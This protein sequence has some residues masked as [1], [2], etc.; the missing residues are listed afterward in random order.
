MSTFV[1]NTSTCLSG[2]FRSFKKHHI[3][4]Y[5]LIWL[6]H[7]KIDYCFIFFVHCISWCSFIL[8]AGIL[9]FYLLSACVCDQ[10]S[11][12]KN[13]QKQQKHFVMR[14]SHGQIFQAVWDGCISWPAI[15]VVQSRRIIVFFV[16]ICCSHLTF[17]SLIGCNLFL[18]LF[19]GG[20]FTLIL[21]VVSTSLSIIALPMCTPTQSV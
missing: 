21:F 15:V 14:L 9:L 5:S 6:S 10:L 7:F 4:L 12:T 1:Q 8:L 16:N 17:T 11:K 2:S 13:I 18:F 3:C 20:T 19:L